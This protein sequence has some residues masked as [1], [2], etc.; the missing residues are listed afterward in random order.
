MST[1]KKKK[2]LPPVPGTEHFFR[3]KTLDDIDDEEDEEKEL[4]L[5]EMFRRSSARLAEEH[6]RIKKKNDEDMQKLHEKLRKAKL[7]LD[8]IPNPMDRL[9]QVVLSTKRKSRK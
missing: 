6:A 2:I 3:P 8:S 5:L 1:H 9:R 7:E 4:S